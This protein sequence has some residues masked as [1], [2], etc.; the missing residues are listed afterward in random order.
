[1]GGTNGTSETSGTVS[2]RLTAPVSLDEIAGSLERIACALEELVRTAKEKENLPPTPPIR[3]KDN[4]IEIQPTRAR[5][6]EE[7]LTCE[8]VLVPPLDEVKAVAASL[9]IP[10]DTAED[11]WSTNMAT[12]WT[13]KG[14]KITAWHHL[15]RAWHRAVLRSQARE[16]AKLAHIDAKMDERDE[17]RTAHIDAKMDERE[18]RR[19]RRAGG[20]RR[21]AD[22]NVEMSD[23]VREEVR[24]DF[25]F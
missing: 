19:E 16:R 24:R 4:V 18:A 2:T 9:G 14:S 13:Y 10:A 5:T 21:K 3:E 8:G 1:M 12:G 23:E 15:L 20:G 11:F 17:R 22:N 6:R 25:T 7:N